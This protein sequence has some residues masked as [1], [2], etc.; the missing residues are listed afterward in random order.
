MT[1]LP[2]EY[3][4]VGRKVL[5]TGAGR[6]IGK[7]IA[8]VL[9]EAGA[10]VA[11]NARTP[12]YVEAL[13]AE[14]K[15]AGG[16][17]WAVLGDVTRPEGAQAVVNEARTRLGHVDV[18]I[19]NVGDSVIQPFAARPDQPN[20]EPMS[21]AD[22]RYQI[23]INLLHAV[24]CSRAIAPHFMERRWGK[25]INI[26]SMWGAA[27][28]HG[29]LL[30]FNAATKAGLNMFTQALA[31]EWAPYGI[32]VNAIAPG[33]VPDPVTTGEAGVRA[34]QARAEEEVPLRRVGQLREVGLLALYL[35]S[36]ASNYM[37]GQ[38]L[39]LDGGQSL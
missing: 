25:V 38:V 16:H 24:H 12:Q 36:D 26:S 39:C 29:R 8:R 19:N 35:V 15:A 32:T 31:L 11:I 18:L 5:I 6:G 33:S 3:Q 1:L 37:T 27:P 22:I 10:Q 28:P 2:V 13:V 17:A 20:D 9:C 4:I 30:T 14:I 7:G 21:E 23:D 34:A